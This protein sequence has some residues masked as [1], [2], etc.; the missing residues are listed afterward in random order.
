MTEFVRALVIT[1]KERFEDARKFSRLKVKEGYKTL[2]ECVLQL[3]LRED[4]ADEVQI[5]N[6]R[7]PNSFQFG[8]LK[9]GECIS[10]GGIICHGQGEETFTVDI[11]SKS[12]VYFGIHT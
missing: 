1:D 8:I 6:D 10:N 3:M 12:G 5:F 2:D 7:V 4:G 11:N 9:H